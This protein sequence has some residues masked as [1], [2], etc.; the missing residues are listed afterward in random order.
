M[1]PWQAVQKEGS[2]SGPRRSRTS[3]LAPSAVNGAGRTLCVAGSCAISASSA[4]SGP[5]SVLRWVAA[6]R[7][8]WP[9]RRPAMNAA[10]RSEARSHQCRSSMASSTGRSAARF[11]VSQ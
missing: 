11:S 8:G 2:A 3:S 9:S 7:M 1:A 6:S 5:G 4:G 10:K